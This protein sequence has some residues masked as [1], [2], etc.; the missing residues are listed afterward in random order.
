M[1]ARF[2]S[3]D[4]PIWGEGMF[5]VRIPVAPIFSLE[6][7]NAVNLENLL[8]KLSFYHQHDQRKTWAR[9][10]GS[11]VRLSDDDGL[12]LFSALQ[13]ANDAAGAP[14][15]IE[16]PDPI[17]AS[18]AESDVPPAQSPVSLISPLELLVDEVVT[19]QRDAAHPN[20]FEQAVGRAFR[21][22]GFDVKVLG[23]SG[24]TDVVVSAP[25][26]HERFRAVID[27]KSSSS[28]KVPESQINSLTMA[29]HRASEVADYSV[30]VG[31][32]FAGGN[33]HKFAV[34]FSVAL[35]ETATL[36]E[37]L[38]LHAGTPFGGADLRPLLST[39]GHVAGVLADLRQKSQAIERHWHLIA[40]ILKVVESFNR[41]DEPLAPSAGNL[42]A[43]L[44]NRALSAGIQ[45]SPP[46][47]QE[48]RDALSFLASRAIGILRPVEPD[49]AGYRL[50]MPLAAAIQRLNA[51]SNSLRAAL[52]EAAPPAVSIHPGQATGAL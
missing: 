26:G 19:A 29:Q 50:V 52:I 28:G 38:R 42:H 32:K 39:G 9:L 21:F 35:I 16:V 1:G 12:L 27:A 43:V 6:P 4:P 37:V 18:V 23:Q 51:A 25:L 40:E 20:R 41:L 2:L 46:S 3:A 36:I 30:V 24:R 22:L 45:G 10:R 15:I 13:T 34:D 17:I 5:P 14:A 8:P 7:A 47:E 31:E 33:L 11:P 48:V 49:T 44:V